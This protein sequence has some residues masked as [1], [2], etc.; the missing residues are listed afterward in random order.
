MAKSYQF[1]TSGHP[2]IYNNNSVRNLKIYFS[3]PDN[4]VNDETGLLLFIPG[5]G[6]QANSNVYKKMRAVFADKYNLVTIQCDYFGW[7]FMQLDQLNETI[8]NFNDMGLLQA[9]DNITAVILVAEVLKDNNF[10]FNSDRIWIYGHSHGAYLAYLCNVFAPK[11]FSMIIDNSAWLF[12]AYLQKNRY[13][14]LNGTTTVFDYY[15]KNI[16]KD[17]AVL[18][19]LMLYQDFENNCEIYSFH[20]ESDTLVTLDEKTM[21]CKKVNNCN[22]KQIDQS[23]I[24]QK[25]F[26]S[27][28]H[29]LGADFLGLFDYVVS[30][31]SNKVYN[32]V[33]SDI[34]LKN[35]NISTKSNTYY[36]D[37][38]G[39][40]PVLSISPNQN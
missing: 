2:N 14:T 35:Q 1:D 3:E 4:G 38:S 17:T 27:T 29:G 30:K 33:R 12:P 20:G 5:F 19:L 37:Y 21:F 36:F 7:E 18:S 26:K 32:T 25:I 15:A 13:L 16:L 10:E 9:L 8:D 28:G 34:V 22:L 11:L 6:G 31:L 39:R 23:D 40:V 24:D